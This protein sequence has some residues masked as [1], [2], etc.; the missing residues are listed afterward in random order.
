MEGTGRE[1]GRIIAYS[2]TIVTKKTQSQ[3]S[4]SSLQ[5]YNLFDYYSITPPPIHKGRGIVFDRFLCF[6]LCFIVSLLATRGW[7]LLCFSTTACFNLFD[8]T[9]VSGQTA[10]VSDGRDVCE[11]NHV[12]QAYYFPHSRHSDSGIFCLCNCCG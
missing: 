1:W 11:Q 7:G 8:W 10:A 2:S 3:K 9:I 6:F 4:F 5:K 12:E